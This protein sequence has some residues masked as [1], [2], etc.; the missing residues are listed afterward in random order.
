[1]KKLLKNFQKVLKSFS[2]PVSSLL[3][4]N[5][6]ETTL[7][8]KRVKDFFFSQNNILLN[9]NDGEHCGIKGLVVTGITKSLQEMSADELRQYIKTYFATLNLGFPIEMITNIEPISLESYLMKVE[10]EL[11]TVELIVESNPSLT[12]AKEKLR[13]L[14]TMKENVVKLGIPPFKITSYILLRECSPSINDVVNI[15]DRRTNLV[16]QALTSAGL[17]MKELKAKSLKDLLRRYSGTLPRKKRKLIQSLMNVLAGSIYA[18]P[19]MIV[20]FPALM[21][22]AGAW[23][24]RISGILLGRNIFT[25]MPVFWDMEEMPSPHTV[26]VGPT[27][28]G[29]TEFLVNLVKK[30][31]YAYSSNTLIIDVKGEYED[32]LLERGVEAI[33]YTLGK[34][35]CLDFKNLG[36]LFPADMRSSVITEEI[37]TNLRVKDTELIGILYDLIDSAVNDW[38]SD[39]LESISEGVALYENTYRTFQLKKIIKKLGII[40][41]ECRNELVS[42]TINFLTGK[43]KYPTIIDLSLIYSIDPPL[44]SLAVSALSKA[45]LSAVRNMPATLE[46]GWKH[47]VLDEGWLFTKEINDV[48]SALLR[49]GRSYKISVSIA[50]QDLDDLNTL[51]LSVISNTGLLVAMPTP[52]RK[53]WKELGAYMRINEDEIT[54]YTS[55]LSRGECVVR[56]LGDPRGIPIRY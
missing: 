52:E 55:L 18:S 51:G 5:W 1:M 28:S 12:S 6:S 37:A 21:W 45:L 36:N 47:L 7:K 23:F 38:E 25:N 14:E 13:H 56:I 29:K 35:L 16:Q 53:Y 24:S 34:N 50:T 39:F 41:S 26:V 2:G 44:V 10:K 54:F 32:R 33:N 20:F 40:S 31:R 3:A 42:T 27:G 48:V 8:D 15:L 9:Y 30:I 43:Q 17:K 49:L 46:A 11:D 4:K 19:A 22:E